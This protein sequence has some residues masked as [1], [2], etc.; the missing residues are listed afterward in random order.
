MLQF[1]VWFGAFLDP[2]TAVAFAFAALIAWLVGWQHGAFAIGGMALMLAAS[3]LYESH[4]INALSALPDP[5][6]YSIA[7]LV[8]IKSGWVV[9]AAIAGPRVASTSLWTTGKIVLAIMVLPIAMAFNARMRRSS[10]QGLMLKRERLLHVAR[11]SW[12]SLSLGPIDLL[13]RRL[14]VT[15]RRVLLVSGFLTRNMTEWLKRDL[16][17]V[18][19]QQRWWGRLTNSGD[20]VLRTRGRSPTTISALY[21]PGMAMQAIRR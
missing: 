15:D 10:D 16:V 7:A 19:L 5:Y 8:C 4:L 13:T 6:L 3:P 1:I 9:I 20:L 12:W 2:S 21:S 14:L 18:D 17:A 11:P